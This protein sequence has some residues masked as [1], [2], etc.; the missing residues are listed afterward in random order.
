[1]GMVLNYS[2]IILKSM[3]QR[4]SSQ[5]V[6][7]RVH[8]LHQLTSSTAWWLQA[9]GSILPRQSPELDRGGGGTAPSCSSAGVGNPGRLRLATRPPPLLCPCSH[10]PPPS[11]HQPSPQ[12][13]PHPAQP[14]LSWMHL[15]KPYFQTQSRSQLLG[16]GSFGGTE[17]NLGHR[18][19]LHV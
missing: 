14:H 9:P 1:M 5:E 17:S 8:C 11:G 10:L 3:Q 19:T 13:H 12:S 18:E 6:C 2:K 16:D 7:N 4:F 15:Q